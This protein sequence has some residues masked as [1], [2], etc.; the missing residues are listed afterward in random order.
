MLYYQAL[1]FTKIENDVTKIRKAY[2]KLSQIHHPD[3]RGDEATFSRIQQAYNFLTNIDKKTEY[4]YAIK[5]GWNHTEEFYYNER[6]DYPAFSD[7]SGTHKAPDQPSSWETASHANAKTKLRP[8]N[9]DAWMSKV[10]NICQKNPQGALYHVPQYN[11]LFFN[12]S[13]TLADYRLGRTNTIEGIEQEETTALLKIIEK[14]QEASPGK[15]RELIVSQMLAPFLR[16]LKRLKKENGLGDFFLNHRDHQGNTA[17]LLL[18]KTELNTELQENMLKDLLDLGSNPDTTNNEN[19]SARPYLSK[20]IIFSHDIKKCG[21]ASVEKALNEIR[22]IVEDH[23]KHHLNLPLNRP[24]SS[25]QKEKGERTKA[26]CMYDYLDILNSDPGHDD[27][28]ESSSQVK[29][30]QEKLSQLHAKF[31]GD[32][33]ILIKDQKNSVSTFFGRIA[34]I[35]TNLFKPAEEKKYST[36]GLAKCGFFASHGERT[37][38]LATEVIQTCVSSPAA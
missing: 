4:D 7:F 32:K 18:A 36:L 37:F 38:T 34:E 13:Q 19:E 27:G 12:H 11:A 20:N 25:Y 28:N 15:Q 1:G 14:V 2:L 24:R 3:K 35:F 16:D 21:K 33:N 26:D 29:H 6:F 30:N 22:A 9:F 17:I 5:R 31:R 10:I 8:G 23:I